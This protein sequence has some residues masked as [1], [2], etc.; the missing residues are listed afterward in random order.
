MRDHRLEHTIPC[1]YDRVDS[2]VQVNEQRGKI[3]DHLT[4]FLILNIDFES[5]IK[6]LLLMVHIYHNK[7]RLSLNM[8]P[9]FGTHLI[10]LFL[11]CFLF[12]NI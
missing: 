11:F 6:Q 8:L 2:I 4:F 3:E 5:L 1:S 10:Y 7:Y 9:F 12:Y